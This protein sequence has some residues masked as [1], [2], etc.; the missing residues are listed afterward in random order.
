MIN[1]TAHLKTTPEMR[2]CASEVNACT[3]LHSRYVT[4]PTCANYT[5]INHHSRIN[6]LP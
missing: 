3:T 4:S 1:F 6:L 2:C 5:W